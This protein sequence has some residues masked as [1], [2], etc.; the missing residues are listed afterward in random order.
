MCL[1]IAAYCIGLTCHRATVIYLKS[2]KFKM[3]TQQLLTWGN[4]LPF[5]DILPP[6]PCK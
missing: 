3:S 5:E 6:F 4:F 1:S 2:N